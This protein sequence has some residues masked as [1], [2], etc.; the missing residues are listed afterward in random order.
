MLQRVPRECIAAVVV[1]GFDGREGEEPHALA[2]GHASREKGDARTRSVEEET[3]YRV[4][5]QS[6][7]CVGDVQT[8]VARME[9]D[10]KLSVKMVSRQWSDHDY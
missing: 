5:V 7:K 8:V 4:I 9:G 10:W 1:D 3:F 6:T 2:V